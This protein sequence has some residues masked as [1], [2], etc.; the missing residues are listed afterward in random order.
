MD[1]QITIIAFGIAS[2]T[3]EEIKQ[4]GK[5][6]KEVF[7]SYF[8]I[9]EDNVT[10]VLR[11]LRNALEDLY[12]VRLYNGIRLARK[13]LKKISPNKKFPSLRHFR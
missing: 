10:L 13:F 12:A 1:Y 11:P 7:M 8:S 5:F 4:N 2:G 9:K 6:V 3:S